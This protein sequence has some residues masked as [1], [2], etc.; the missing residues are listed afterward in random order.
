MRSS[1]P[2]PCPRWVLSGA[3]CTSRRLPSRVDLPTPAEAYLREEV[4]DLPNRAN[5]PTSALPRPGTECSL[6]SE[7]PVNS[8]G[9][10]VM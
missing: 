9:T 4:G 7:P 8:P 1:S 3:R 5:Q 2:G 10:G 6:G